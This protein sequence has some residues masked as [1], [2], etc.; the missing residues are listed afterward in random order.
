VA[1][2]AAFCALCS[3]VRKLQEMFHELCLTVLEDRPLRNEV[4]LIDRLG[5][6]V[7]D[8][9]GWIEEMG[10][11]AAEAEQGAAYPEDM[12]RASRAL[13]VCQERFMRFNEQFSSDL[14]SYECIEELNRFGAERGRECLHWASAVRQVLEEAREP[15][16]EVNAALFVCWQELTERLGSAS[17]LVQATN[18][19]QQVCHGESDI[20]QLSRG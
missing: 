14:S 16:R 10:T 9:M 2:A 19:G 15:M 7:Q 12:H 13:A 4:V 5:Y 6:A 18:I 8:A 17:V 1:L 3:D 11:A 20:K